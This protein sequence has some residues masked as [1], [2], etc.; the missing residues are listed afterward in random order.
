VK[1][2]GQ[3]GNSKIHKTNRGTSHVR[4]FSIDYQKF[5]QYKPCGQE[6][7]KE[8]RERDRLIEEKEG[9]KEGRE[10]GR[11]RERKQARKEQT[12]KENPLLI[13]TTIPSYIILP[14]QRKNK[15]FPGKQKL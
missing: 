3:R 13:K 9:R 2:Q 10:G 12:N 7:K 8:E 15:M 11:K 14:K 5:S 4:E 1:S 6:R